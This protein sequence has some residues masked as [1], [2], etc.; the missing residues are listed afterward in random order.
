[1][2]AIDDAI[3]V[4]SEEDSTAQ[5]RFLHNCRPRDLTRSKGHPFKSQLN[6]KIR[7]PI[8]RHFRVRLDMVDKSGQ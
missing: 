1:M 6:L 3:N 7:Y 4:R 2:E 5:A 8:G